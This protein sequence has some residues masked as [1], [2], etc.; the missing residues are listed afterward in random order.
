VLNESTTK[1][2]QKEMLSEESLRTIAQHQDYRD[3]VAAVGSSHKDFK[4]SLGDGT[5]LKHVFRLVLGNKVDIEE[6][7]TFIL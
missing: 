2:T 6:S 5:I 3:C 7:K 4:C 1:A